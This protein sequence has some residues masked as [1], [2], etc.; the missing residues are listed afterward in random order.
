MQVF[1]NGGAVRYG[2]LLERF[3]Q[4]NIRGCRTGGSIADCKSTI[5][6]L[7]QWRKQRRKSRHIYLVKGNTRDEIVEKA[8]ELATWASQHGTAEGVIIEPGK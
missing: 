2:K 4:L 8:S 7:S 5:F 3:E 6:E 1:L